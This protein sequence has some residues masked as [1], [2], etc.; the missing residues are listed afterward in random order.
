MSKSRFDFLFRPVDNASVAFFR[1]AFGGIMVWEVTRYF[2]HGWIHRYWIAPPFHFSYFGFDWVEPLPPAYMYA[3]M[4]AGG[5]VAAMIALGLFYRVAAVLWFIGFTYT[6]LLE[7]AR[8][9]NHFYLIILLSFLLIVI[10]THRGFSIDALFRKDLRAQRSP[11]WGLWLLR[12][13]MAVVYIYGG[14]AKINGDWLRGEPVRMWIKD[15]TDLPWVGD[16]F[17]TEPAVYI[18]AY[19]GML[20]DLLIVFF[21]AWRPTRWFAFASAV[22]FHVTNTVWFGIGVFPWLALAAT[23]LYFPPDWPRRLLRLAPL[24]AVTAD[25]PLQRWSKPIGAVVIVFVALQVLVPLRHHLYPGDVAWTEEGHRFSWRMKL[26]SKRGSVEYHIYD[27]NNGTLDV[28]EPE[29]LMSRW[30]H[31]GIAGRPDMIIEFAKHIAES[32]GDGVTVTAH[33]RVSLNGRKKQ[34]IIDPD[35]D[36]LTEE[37]R[38][39]PAA[40]WIVPLEQPFRNSDE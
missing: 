35:R 5:V 11:A 27:P 8:Y 29:D 33:T 14:I 36:L 37:R 9:L 7:E 13:Q 25:V 16:F 1:I 4:W 20:F 30:Q 34:Y 3:L 21:V 6:F 40:D 23:T 22:I 32:Y 2:S 18:V 28:V 12:F 26:R 31:K 10:P 19:G 39:W 24:P 38:L 17:Y 15:L